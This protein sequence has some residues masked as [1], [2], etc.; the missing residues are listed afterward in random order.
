MDF[1]GIT[2]VVA[3]TVICFLVG[4]VIKATG[5]DN[6]WIPVIVGVAGGFL[7]IA[8]MFIIP[9]FPAADYINAA[10]VGIVSGL[11]STG[12]NQIYKQ[13]KNTEGE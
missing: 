3:I 5:I 13:T 9:D 2:S 12:A 6:K 7:G 10:A 8:G 1:T 11:A 4:Q